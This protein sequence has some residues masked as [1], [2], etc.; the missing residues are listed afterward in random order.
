MATKEDLAEMRDELRVAFKVDISELR[1]ELTGEIDSLRIEM[2]E[3]FASIRAELR[4]IRQ[5][6]DALEE[7]AR[8]SAGLTK[9]ID[10]IMER[11]GTIEKHLGIQH[12]IAA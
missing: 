11:V 2:Q 4:D 7:A 9:E 5:R 10:H 8:N 3:G 1:G 12:R 6:L